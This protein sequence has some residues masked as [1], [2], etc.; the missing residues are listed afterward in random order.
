MSRQHADCL[1]HEKSSGDGGNFL[2]G[3]PACMN[4]GYADEHFGEVMV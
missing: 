2:L 3:T 1:R 4:F